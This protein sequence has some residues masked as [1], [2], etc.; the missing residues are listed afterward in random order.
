[1]AARVRGVV[2]IQ[3]ALAKAPTANGL[4]DLGMAQLRTFREIYAMKGYRH[5]LCYAEGLRAQIDF[6]SDLLWLVERGWYHAADVMFDLVAG[7]GA[8]G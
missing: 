4:R 1:M 7:E 2:C 3:E 6:M 5:A 8:E